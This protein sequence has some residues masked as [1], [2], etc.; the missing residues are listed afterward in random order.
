MATISHKRGDSV[1]WALTVSVDG[2]AA[3]ITDWSI[4]AQLR[5]GSTL[6]ESL[7]V[8]KTNS[9]IGVFVISATATETASWAVGSHSCDVEFTQ[10]SDVFST[11]TFTLKVLE[12]I[13]RD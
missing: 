13:T 4:R 8:T 10:G 1:E 7:T 3:D 9:S 5:Q 6:T 2:S 12:D 11:E